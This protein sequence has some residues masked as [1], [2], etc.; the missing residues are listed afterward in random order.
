MATTRKLLLTAGKLALV[1]VVLASLAQAAEYVAPHLRGRPSGS[2]IIVNRP[3]VFTV[4]GHSK[5]FYPG[6]K[7]PMRVT[8]ANPNPFP[9]VV[10]RVTASVRSVASGCPMK[11]VKIKPWHGRAR[12]A[13]RGH[14]RMKLVVRMLPRTPDA[15]QGARFRLRFGGTAVR[16]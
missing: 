4:K 14:R 7:R 1:L 11:S 5:G 8:V 13:T 9:I 16:A 12:V 2:S 10:T 15:C 6:R 3:A